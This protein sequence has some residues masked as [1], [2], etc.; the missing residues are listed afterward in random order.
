MMK[1]KS[2]TNIKIKL[3]F[4]DIFVEVLSVIALIV[5]WYLTVHFHQLGLEVA[6]QSYKFFENPNE[7]WAT[8]MTYT[9]PIMATILSIGLTYYYSKESYGSYPVEIKPENQAQM[10]LINRR[11]WRWI[12]LNVLVVFILIEY[13]SFHTGSN[14]GTGI[15]FWF[16][17]AFPVI[18]FGP[19]IYFF[20]EF[21]KNQLQ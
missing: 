10:I 2:T 15:S 5:L 1:D 20:L 16:I 8:K 6:P 14:A 12:K 18:L 19:V 3:G 7:Y 9:L 4:W 21:S 13:F 17:L 11:L